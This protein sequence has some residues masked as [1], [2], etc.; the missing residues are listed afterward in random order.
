MAPRVNKPRPTYRCRVQ[1]RESG[2]AESPLTAAE[3]QALKRDILKRDNAHATQVR[4][5]R[6]R[7]N[8]SS[9]VFL[10][11]SLEIMSFG[12]RPGLRRRVRVVYAHC[13]KHILVHRGMSESPDTGRNILFVLIIADTFA[14]LTLYHMHGKACVDT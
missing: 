13:G 6:T 1:D 2:D 4:Q 3:E 10:C 12:C 8:V 5:D 7:Q 14:S 11:A 9:V